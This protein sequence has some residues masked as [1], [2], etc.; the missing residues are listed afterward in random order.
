MSRI[1]ELLEALAPIGRNER[2]GYDRLAWSD[3]DAAMRRWFLA[4]AADLGL[5]TEVDRNG[6]L[7]A[8]GRG[9]TGPRL[10]L[11]SH[12]DSVPNG[13]ALDGPLGVASAFAAMR[14]LRDAGEAPASNVSVVAFVDEEGGRFGLACLGSRLTTGAVDPERA[15]ALVDRDGVRLDEAMRAAGLDPDAVGPDP[16]RVGSLGAYVELHV[17]QG[18]LPI[19]GSDAAGLAAADAPLGVL[20]GIWPHGRWRIDVAGHANHA[21]TT[22]MAG[23]DD[24]VVGAAG[25]VL[26]ARDAAVAEGALATVGRVEVEPG[27]VNAIAVRASLWLD[28]RGADEGR[29]R[30]VVARVTAAAGVAPVEE[31]W[32]GAM[33]FARSET[34]RLAAVV[35]EVTGTDAPTLP[36]GAGH[37]AGVLQAAGV[38]AA[39]LAVRNPTGI[40]HAPGE[41]A[42]APDMDLGVAA[43]AL[44]LRRSSP[45][46]VAG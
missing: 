34:R 28:V 5:E 35:R 9:G 32:T 17:E 14:S 33:R 30:R 12:L 16:G 11:G 2:G 15:R 22:P 13:G 6:N 36:S 46:R 42:A 24:P 3:A 21:G 43:L 38:P 20:T 31:S 45:D 25:V 40:S 39:M 8:H 41:S 26:A 27:A 23:R 44:L 4:E 1:A 10:V 37:D 7:W 19:D 18:H 29:I